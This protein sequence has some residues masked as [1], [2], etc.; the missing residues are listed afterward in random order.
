MEVL[1][2]C[3][4][5]HLFKH[6]LKTE[7]DLRIWSKI[8]LIAFCI[9]YNGEFF[10]GEINIG[11]TKDFSAE[12]KAQVRFQNGKVYLRTQQY[13]KA[14]RLFTE[15]VQF[16]EDYAEAYHFRGSTYYYLKKYDNACL[17]WQKAC[18]LD[19]SCIGWN[20]GLYQKICQSHRRKTNGP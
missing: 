1:I 20:F 6:A 19:T 11:S 16:K 5:K 12:I 13:E 18:N 17:D 8:I 2:F 10:F 15:A 3:V 14:I 7:R 4:I 9:L